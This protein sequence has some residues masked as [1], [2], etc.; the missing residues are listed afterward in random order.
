MK[1]K[2]EEE[3]TP[4]DKDLNL[5]DVEDQIDSMISWF[6]QLSSDKQRTFLRNVIH[7]HIAIKPKKSGE[8]EQANIGLMTGLKEHR[9]I[10]VAR[11][12]NSNSANPKHITDK[13]DLTSGAV[14]CHKTDMSYHIFDLGDTHPEKAK[15][16]QELAELD[17]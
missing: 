9:S 7:P 1:K 12:L 11:K 15:I 6:S 5:F 14:N 8:N 17:Q 3:Y 2:A 4:K 16:L 13:Y 10:C